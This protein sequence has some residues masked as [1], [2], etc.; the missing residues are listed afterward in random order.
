MRIIMMLMTIINSRRVK[1]CKARVLRV[2][3]AVSNDLWT[4]SG[5]S[6]YK[7]YGG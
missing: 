3:G 7:L 6:D 2:F 4:I 5:M 1:P